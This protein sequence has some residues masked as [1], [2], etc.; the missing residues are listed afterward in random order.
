MTT[1][2]S[3][4]EDGRYV[5][6]V[7]AADRPGSLTAVAE[8]VSSRGPSLDSL[9]SGNLRDGTAVIIPSFTASGRLSG[10]S[11][12]PWRAWQSSRPSTSCP[13]TIPPSLPPG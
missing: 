9:A 1:P 5:A 6:Y 4:I 7:C 11:N 13:R 10:W 2:A 3:T 12:A 8:V